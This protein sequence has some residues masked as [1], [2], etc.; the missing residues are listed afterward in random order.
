MQKSHGMIEGSQNDLATQAVIAADFGACQMA[1][2]DAALLP[3]NPGRVASAL[4]AFAFATCGNIAKAETLANSLNKD[5]PLETFAQKVDIPMIRAREQLQRG[6]GAK[7][8]DELRPT[9]LYEFGIIAKGDPP[10]LRGLA[11]LEMKQGVQAAAEFQKLIDHKGVTGNTPYAALSRLGLGRAYA[12]AG[13]NSK[14]RT[15]YQDFFALWKDADSDVPILK[16]AK[17]EYEQLK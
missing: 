4:A 7:A 6:N 13:D 9:E 12:S 11:Y 5:Y 15:A 2:Q 8:L 17:A 1:N 3:A 14:A 10:Y 16:T